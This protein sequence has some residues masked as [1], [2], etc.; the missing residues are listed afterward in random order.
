MGGYREVEAEELVLGI[1][2]HRGRGAEAEEVD[3]P[4]LDQQVDG[5]ADQLRVEALQGAVQGGDGAAE[6]LP[7]VG[8]G[9]VVGGDRLAHVG[10]AAGQALGQLHLQFRVA[11]DAEGAAEAVHRRLADLRRLGQRGNAVAG[12]LLRVAQY[13]FGDLAL[14]LVEL[15]E[16]VLDLFQQVVHAVHLGSWKGACNRWPIVSGAGCRNLGYG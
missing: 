12:G 2:G 3:L 7:G 4:G 14:G 8:L 1:Q 5:A 16:A 11:V 9:A 10:G 13:H 6:D 15:V